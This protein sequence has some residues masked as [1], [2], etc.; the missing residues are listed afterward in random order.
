LFIF[1]FTN[2]H[3]LEIVSRASKVDA[4]T[5]KSVAQDLPPHHCLVLGKVVNDFPIVAKV[6]KL[7]VHA[8]GQTRLFFSENSM[9]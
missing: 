3:D 8:K 9:D 4:E 2:E 5:V 7:N 6:K 1:N